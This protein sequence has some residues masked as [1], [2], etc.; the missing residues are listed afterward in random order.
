MLKDPKQVWFWKQFAFRKFCSPT[1]ILWS[2]SSHLWKA[3][4]KISTWSCLSS[5]VGPVVSSHM[6]ASLYKLESVTNTNLAP[7]FLHPPF[8]MYTIQKSVFLNGQMCAVHS[9]TVHQCIQMDAG[10]FALQTFAKPPLFLVR[11]D[12]V[13]ASLYLVILVICTHLQSRWC[14]WNLFTS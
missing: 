5:P 12:K 2:S 10:M 11:T 3:L 13:E 14:V 4:V 8:I 7:D 1:A 6:L 9:H